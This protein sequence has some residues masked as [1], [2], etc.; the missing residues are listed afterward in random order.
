MFTVP[1]A[2][3]WPFDWSSVENEMARAFGAIRECARIAWW[4]GS[5]IGLHLHGVFDLFDLLDTR[6]DPDRGDLP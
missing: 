1:R 5:A 3:P 2:R 6:P 4:D